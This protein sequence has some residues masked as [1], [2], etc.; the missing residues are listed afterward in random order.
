MKVFL[1]HS[2]IRSVKL[3]KLF[4]E[5]LPNVIQNVDPWI[6]D[7]IKKGKLWRSEI[8]T[9][10]EDTKIGVICLTQTNLLSP[11][12]LFEAGALSK[13]RDANVNTFLLDNE[14]SDISGPLADFQHTIFEKEDIRKLIIG[15]NEQQKIMNEKSLEKSRLNK[16][17]EKYWNEFEE[18]ASAIKSEKEGKEEI[19]RA[20]R[21]K[22]DILDEVLN[23]IRRI[24]SHQDTS[25]IICRPE[26][27]KAQKDFL[28]TDNSKIFRNRGELLNKLDQLEHDLNIER[29][30][31]KIMEKK[32]VSKMQQI[33]Q[34]K[35]INDL[36]EIWQTVNNTIKYK[37]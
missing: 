20:K 18:P 32:K 26:I 1:S 17:F 10:L 33:E 25:E 35:R 2:G 3:A 27:L 36:T 12:I 15:I 7:D 23:R 8:S 31:L 19:K 11:W 21:D 6:S 37:F 30:K 5:W 4:Q 13:T 24:E 22:E 34:Q 9:A 29:E 14:P 28:W 16:A